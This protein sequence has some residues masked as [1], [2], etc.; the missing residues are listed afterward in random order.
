M[1]YFLVFIMVLALG[2]LWLISRGRGKLSDGQKAD[3]AT[4]WSQ[5]KGLLDRD[6][7]HAWVQAVMQADKLLDQVLRWRGVSGATLGERLKNGKSWLG[8]LENDVWQAHKL[9]N[10][11]AH[12]VDARVSGNEARRAVEN[13]G[14]AI[15]RMIG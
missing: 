10:N 8:N 2:G 7:E 1:W 12:E 5:I 13:L 3:V 4:K 14:K 11:L 6:D 9:R 15:G